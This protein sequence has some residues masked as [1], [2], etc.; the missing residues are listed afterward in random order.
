M[1]A[2]D[3]AAISPTAIPGD[4]LRARMD[5]ETRGG[6][7]GTL[8]ENLPDGPIDVAL[9]RALDDRL[10]VDVE[11]SDPPRVE[12]VVRPDG[13]ALTLRVHEPAN[14][15]AR[16]VAG[17][18]VLWIHGGGMFLG[19]AATEDVFC[20]GL[21]SR[22][23]ATVPGATVVA[24][25]YQLAPEHPH[26]AA[27]EDCLAALAWTAAR[28]P[29]VVVAGASAGG[30]LAAGLCLAARDAGGPAIAAAHLL[31]PML[32]DRHETASARELADTAVWN[33]RLADLAWSAYLGGRDADAYAAPSRADD[34][35]GFPS[36]YLEVGE[37]DLFRDEDALFAGRLAAA[38]VPI[39]F[40]LVAKAVH[41]FELIAPDAAISRAAVER[42]DAALARALAPSPSLAEGA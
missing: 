19:S 3:R 14:P 1:I 6:L 7:A 2:A 35:S 29:R 4:E 25:D 41:A 9:I 28:H 8:A 20:A 18:A 39:E 22:L 27:L 15:G 38:G 24:V 36:T 42:R 17:P 32:D 34:L 12:S 5:P 33:R 26:P 16:G 37:L 40:E 11:P 21:A 30:G 13:S 23:G 31:Y 10:R